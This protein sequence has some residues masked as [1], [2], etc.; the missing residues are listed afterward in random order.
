MGLPK[1][2]WHILQVWT[3]GA[4][5]MLQVWAEGAWQTSIH[6]LLPFCEC[7]TNTRTSSPGE[8]ARVCQVRPMC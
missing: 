3:E 2:A 5:P 8:T 6:L 4:W 7:E 1:G